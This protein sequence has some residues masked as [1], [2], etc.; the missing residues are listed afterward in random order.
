MR[1]KGANRVVEET[2]LINFHYASI[3]Q[4]EYSRSY[5]SSKCQKPCF[6]HLLKV[7][8]AIFFKNEKFF[9]SSGPPRQAQNNKKLFYDYLRCYGIKRVTKIFAKFYCY[10]RQPFLSYSGKSNTSPVQLVL[11]SWMQA[12]K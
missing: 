9:C 1:A 12:S 4:N 3:S 2:E 6:S 7:R 10:N 5:G 11:K 8:V